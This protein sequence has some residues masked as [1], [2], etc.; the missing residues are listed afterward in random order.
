MAFPKDCAL[1]PGSLVLVTGANGYVGSHAVDQFL[2]YGYKVRGT[3]RNKQKCAWLTQ[4]FDKKYGSG[5]FELVELATLDD[6][7]SFKA[8]ADGCD[9]IVHVAQGV[10][11]SS[12]PHEVITPA[13]NCT[14][15]AL[16]AAATTPSVKRFVY[17]SSSVAVRGDEV[18]GPDVQLTPETW[19]DAVLE[20]V[21]APGPYGMERM[22]PSYMASKVLCERKVWEFMAER[23]PNFVA[24]AVLPDY[25]I[26]RPVSVEHQGL[27]FS[28]VM[29]LKSL[30]DGE[31]F[32]RMFGP[33]YMVD[34]GDIGRLHVA[35]LTKAD[36]A[37][38]RIFGFAHQKTWTDWI[39]L[40]RQ[41]HPEK[42][43]P[44]PPPNEGRDEAVITARPRAEAMLKWLG[45]PAGWRPMEESVR[46]TVDLMV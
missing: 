2:T 4:V 23:K 37:N 26:G 36:A 13:V 41:D 5:K 31:D 42:T 17:T 28:T 14:V 24:N 18:R 15:V 6:L 10:G 25:V 12:D 35:A 34:A 22:M 32:W 46:E 20:N 16:E 21:W 7:E 30:V 29:V 27:A 1:P 38:E 33:N 43:F 11:N 19:N 9:G 39:A 8:A 40:M 3:V 44:D 45:Q